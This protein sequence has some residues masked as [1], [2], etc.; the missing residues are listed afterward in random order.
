MQTLIR[1]SEIGLEQSQYDPVWER[2][3]TALP[4]AFKLEDDSAVAQVR[5]LQAN[6]LFDQGE[7]AAA[8]TAVL[9]S[10]AL[11]EEQNQLR[12]LAKGKDLLGWIYYDSHAE[13]DEA[14]VAANE[15]L[16]IYERIGF[17]ADAISALRVKSSILHHQKQ[18]EQALPFAQ[19]AYELSQELN[20]VGETVACL[21]YLAGINRGIGKL[22]IGK[23]AAEEGLTMAKRIGTIRW[24]GLIYLELSMINHRLQNYD[25]SQSQAD[26]A[27]EIF[28]QIKDQLNYGYAILQAGDAAQKLDRPEQ[29]QQAWS[30]AKQVAEALSHAD[31]LAEVSARQ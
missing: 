25:A 7:Y 14:E 6:I 24:E 1:W 15:A 29:S 3:E 11:L 27:A 8:E 31:L 17:S 28:E 13:M 5:F 2:L 30:V 4:L 16:T 19:K 18:G 26:Q 12:R 10:I 22:E 23:M 20:N 21:Y 9:E